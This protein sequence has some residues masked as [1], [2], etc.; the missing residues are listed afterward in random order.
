MLVHNAKRNL[1]YLSS[2]LLFLI[3]ITHIYL[4]AGNVSGGPCRLPMATQACFCS[5]SIMK[6]KLTLLRY[7]FALTIGQPACASQ[8]YYS[9]SQRRRRKEGEFR[10]RLIL[11]F[12]DIVMCGGSAAV[13]RV[14]TATVHCSSGFFK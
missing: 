1:K 8:Y 10:V 6:Q 3:I 4:A 14:Q 7:P 2:K 11:Q 9:R 12:C 5:W 13:E